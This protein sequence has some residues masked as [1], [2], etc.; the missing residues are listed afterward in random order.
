MIREMETTTIYKV[1]TNCLDIL[2]VTQ[3]ER[4]LNGILHQNEKH[5]FLDFS[6]VEEV[7]SAVLG[8]IIHKKMKL[9]KEGREIYLLHTTKS[10][11]RIL[12]ILKLS[13]LLMFHQ[14]E[15]NLSLQLSP[16]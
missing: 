5:V 6:E 7:S 1:E 2:S 10:V 8:I 12:K 14:N 4:E 13:S 15:A 9:K 16:I 11:E 3:F